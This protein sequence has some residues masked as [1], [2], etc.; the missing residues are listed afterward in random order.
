MQL[1]ITLASSSEQEAR[2]SSRAAMK[3]SEF[4]E[5]FGSDLEREQLILTAPGSILT[6]P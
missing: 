2:N 4:C 6:F 1:D 3:T 5:V